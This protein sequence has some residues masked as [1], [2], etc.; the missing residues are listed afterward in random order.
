MDLEKYF[1]SL[2]NEKKISHNVNGTHRIPGVFN[3]TFPNMDGKNL[4]MQLDMNGIGISFG[5]A[6]ASGTTKTSNMLID[7]GLSEEDALSTVRISFGKIHDRDDIKTV[8][9]SINDIFNKCKKKE[10]EN[11]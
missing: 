10:M 5:A 4:V 1:L 7:M 2:L 8:I 3:I 6:C 9:E 11:A